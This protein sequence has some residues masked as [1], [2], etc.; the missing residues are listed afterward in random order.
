MQQW[1]LKTRL[2]AC[3]ARDAPQTL[4]AKGPAA[5]VI[6]FRLEASAIY[7]EQLAQEVFFETHFDECCADGAG[8]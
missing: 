5:D 6:D 4:S 2:G 7:F 8:F 1:H 3:F